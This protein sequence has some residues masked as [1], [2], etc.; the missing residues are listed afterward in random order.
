MK[1]FLWIIAVITLAGCAST[2][3]GPV[4]SALVEQAI[5]Q[6]IAKEMGELTQ[7]DLERVVT[8]DLI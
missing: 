5:R 1:C 3:T 4:Q 2:S 6:A 8:L 7:A